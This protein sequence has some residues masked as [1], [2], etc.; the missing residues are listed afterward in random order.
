MT[1]SPCNSSTKLGSEQ[2]P[3]GKVLPTFAILMWNPVSFVNKYV[4]LGQLFHTSQ[5]NLVPEC[6]NFHQT[7]VVSQVAKA[8]NLLKLF[9][10]NF[11]QVNKRIYKEK[12]FNIQNQEL[13]CNHMACVVFFLGRQFSVPR[14]N[15][16]T[17]II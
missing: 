3:F 7:V 6:M 8:A 9:F 15:L 11:S 5:Q 14:L 1:I 12:D 13:I 17:H 10:T 4:I 2:L 16:M